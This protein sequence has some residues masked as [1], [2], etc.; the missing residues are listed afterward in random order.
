M[1]EYWLADNRD[2]AEQN[3]LRMLVGMLRTMKEWNEQPTCEELLKYIE[4]KVQEEEER[5]NKAF[6]DKTRSIMVQ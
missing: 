4:E 6:P 5:L 2:F 3:T 1:R